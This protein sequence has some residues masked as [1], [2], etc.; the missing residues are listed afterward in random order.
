LGLGLGGQGGIGRGQLGQRG[1]PPGLQ[2]AR[3]ETVFRFAGQEGPFGTLGAV[4]SA[5]EGEFGG[6]H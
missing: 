3:D 6:T 4:V 1:L 2:A 5:F